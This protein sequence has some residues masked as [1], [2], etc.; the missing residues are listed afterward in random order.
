M[1]ESAPTLSSDT[2]YAERAFTPA[3]WLNLAIASAAMVATLPGRT[4]G[5]AM[6]TEPMLAEL[7]IGHVSY[8]FMNLWAT[9]IGATFALACGPLIDRLGARAVLTGTAVLLCA[10][11]LL[12]SGVT[13]ARSLAIALTLT[14]GFGQS[15]LSVV[16]IALVGKW[17]MR[18]MNVAMGIYAA[19]VA[20]GFAIAIPLVQLGLSR[21]GWRAVLS[22]IAWATLALAIV[23][24]LMARS[25]PPATA[26]NAPADQNAGGVGIRAALSTPAFWVF[27]ISCAAF[28][29]IMSGVTLF[30]QAILRE[31]GLEAQLTPVMALF[32]LAGL[33]ANF[34]GG[35]L[36]E[37]WPLGRLLAASMMAL[38]ISLIILIRAT[39]AAHAMLYGVGLGISGGVVTVVFF[40]C[41]PKMYGRRHLGKIQGTAQALTVLASAVGPYILAIGERRSGAFGPLLLAMSIG[42][43][44]LAVVAMWVP[45]P[46]EPRASAASATGPA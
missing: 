9:L 38:A 1:S 41:W 34:I 5:L 27:A 28:N 24:A 19:L 36:L 39:T 15:A 7:R 31:R 46:P 14:R 8:G 25:R 10:S 43:A 22:D 30:S 21:H 40:A 23:S 32:M 42:V 16:S 29:L 35:W 12:M 4:F 44:V 13:S 45:T 20:I 37:K 11:V 6:L 33:A 17:F 3:A 26:A 18:R 2:D